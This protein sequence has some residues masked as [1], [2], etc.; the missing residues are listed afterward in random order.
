MKTL[1]NK[2]M[3]VVMLAVASATF[4]SLAQAN[5]TVAPTAQVQVNEQAKPLVF[6]EQKAI[7]PSDVAEASNYCFWEYRYVCNAYG[8]CVYRYVYVCF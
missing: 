8:Y 4:V 3:L 5:E 2:I 7:N 1:K 6:D